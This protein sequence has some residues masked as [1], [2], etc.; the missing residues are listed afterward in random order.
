MKKAILAITIV[1]GSIT[2]FTQTAPPT[3]AG[4]HYQTESG[5]TRMELATS[6]GF[7]THGGLKASFSVDSAV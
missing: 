2:A 7:K 6:C 3:L 5:Y 4:M 1:L